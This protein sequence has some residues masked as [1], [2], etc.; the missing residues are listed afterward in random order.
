M[1]LR[2]SAISDSSRARL[3]CGTAAAAAGRTAPRRG[4]CTPGVALCAYMKEG[5]SNVLGACVQV[6]CM[7][8]TSGPRMQDVVHAMVHAMIHAIGS[9]MRSPAHACMRADRVTKCTQAVWE[10]DLA[11]MF[12]H[13][14][15]SRRAR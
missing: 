1:L 15:T 2:R 12:W 11:R 13:G 4:G 7:H 9:C 8:K 5:P 3:A 10:A 6:W 14:S